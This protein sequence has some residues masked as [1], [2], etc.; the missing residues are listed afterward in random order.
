[1]SALRCTLFRVLHR[2]QVHKQLPRSATA[3]HLYEL[4]LSERHF[5]RN[6]KQLTD[7][8]SHQD[9]EGLYEAMTP[10]WYRVLLGLG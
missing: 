1:V 4:A 8:A 3:L 10:A 7:L 9:V 5:A 6:E 2:A